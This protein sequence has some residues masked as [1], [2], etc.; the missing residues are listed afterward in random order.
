MDPAAELAAV[1]EPT[2]YRSWKARE[3]HEYDGWE[4]RFADGF[5]RRCNSVHATGPST[6]PISEKL[7]VCRRWYAERAVDLVVR[8]TPAS[9]DGLDDTLAAAG[10]ALECPTDVMVGSVGEPVAEFEATSAPTPSP[11]AKESTSVGR[12]CPR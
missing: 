7:A 11:S 9:E 12:S 1:I 8:Q 2:V 10:F 5:A 3:L 4:L 6:V